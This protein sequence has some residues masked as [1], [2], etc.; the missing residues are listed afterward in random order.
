MRVWPCVDRIVFKY[1]LLCSE[2]YLIIRGNERT[3]YQRPFCLACAL[4][5]E[6]LNEPPYAY[7]RKGDNCWQLY[8]P[9]VWAWAP[10]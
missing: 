10:E 3:I 9:L 1:P 4:W 8:D 5:I 7:H 6:S 2:I